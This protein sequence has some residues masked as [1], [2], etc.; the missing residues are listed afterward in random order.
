MAYGQFSRLALQWLDMWEKDV[1]RESLGGKPT[2][3]Q[4]NLPRLQQVLLKIREADEKRAKEV[5]SFYYD[6]RE[7]VENIARIIKLK[8]YAVFVIANRKVKGVVLPTDQLI[9]DMMLPLGFSHI[10]TLQ[11]EIPNKRMPSR[12]SP[13]NISGETDVTMLKEHIVLFMKDKGGEGLA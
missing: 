9:V 6:L 4:T 11:R 8:G 5:E 7:C 13:S 12:N 10:G 3:H 2:A 1:D